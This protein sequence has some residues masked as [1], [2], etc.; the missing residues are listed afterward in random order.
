M[1]I[2]IYTIGTLVRT[3]VRSMGGRHTPAIPLMRVIG[4]NFVI[5]IFIKE[6]KPKEI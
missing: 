3:A 6:H 4:S 5:Y 2:L 1:K